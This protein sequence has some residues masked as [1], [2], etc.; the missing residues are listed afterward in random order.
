MHIC[1]FFSFFVAKFSKLILP[2][3]EGNLVEGR[4]RIQRLQPMATPLTTMA[5]VLETIRN[6]TIGLIRPGVFDLIGE[7]SSW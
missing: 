1:S 2:L 6:Y 4:P 7:W 3:H 5:Q